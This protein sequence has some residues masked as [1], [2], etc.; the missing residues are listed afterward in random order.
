V[1]ELDHRVKAIGQVE[2]HPILQ[3]VRGERHERV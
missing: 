3:I 1:L 2:C